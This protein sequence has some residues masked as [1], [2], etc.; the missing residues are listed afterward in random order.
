MLKQKVNLALALLKS[1]TLTE[2]LQKN[3]KKNK[4]PPLLIINIKLLSPDT[5]EF[6]YKGYFVQP[7]FPTKKNH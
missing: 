5:F 7:G 1:C 6:Y 3:V 4:A 2:V